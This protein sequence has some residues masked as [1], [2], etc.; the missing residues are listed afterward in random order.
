MTTLLQFLLE[1][2]GALAVHEAGHLL[3]GKIAGLKLKSIEWKRLA[4]PSVRH[5]R[6]T[7]GQNLTAI[8]GGAAMNFVVACLFF[9]TWKMFAVAD[10]VFG[11]VNLLPMPLSDGMQAMGILLQ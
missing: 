8:L 11:V 6:G 4:G 3:A 9:S 7:W 10:L 1:C 2:A 5:Q